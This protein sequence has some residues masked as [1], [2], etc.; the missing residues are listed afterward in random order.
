MSNLPVSSL[1]Y[2]ANTPVRR[3]RHATKRITLRQAEN[4][5]A[6]VRFATEIGTPLNSHATIHWVGTEA[7]D[8]P[9]LRQVA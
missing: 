7:G 6:A 9:E 1:P 8:D 5:M 2:P 3:T 4:M